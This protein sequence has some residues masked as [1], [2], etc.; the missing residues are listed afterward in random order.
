MGFFSSVFSGRG[1]ATAIYKRGMKK[2]KERDLEGAIS[3]YSSV[4]DLTSAPGDLKAMARFNR[5]L[6]YSMNRDYGKAEEDLQAV[7]TMRET[8]A[9]VLEAAREKLKRWKRRQSGEEPD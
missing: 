8:P 5:G 4:I 7:L 2:A 9:D 1:K 6:A 3:E